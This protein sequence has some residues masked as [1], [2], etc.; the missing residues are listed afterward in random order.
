MV[1]FKDETTLIISLSLGTMYSGFALCTKEITKGDQEECSTYL[2]SFRT[3]SL[4]LLNKEHEVIEYG[5]QAE[6]TFK[7][8]VEK[9]VD[10]E[11]RFFRHFKMTNSIKNVSPNN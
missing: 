9:G 10:K 2:E 7:E 3:Q 6:K 11:Y 1:F 5:I 8:F 4:L